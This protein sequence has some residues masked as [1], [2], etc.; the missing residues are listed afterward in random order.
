M[1]LLGWLRA[2]WQRDAIPPPAADM[3]GAATLAKEKAAN[4]SQES[5]PH[6]VIPPKPAAIEPTVAVLRALDWDK[7]DVWSAALTRACALRGIHTRLRLAAFLANVGHETNGGR[8]LVE[9]LDYAPDRL[10]AVFGLRATPEAQACCRQDG[11]PAD[12]RALANILYGG[13]WGRRNLGNTMP[14]DGWRFRG[15][16]LMQLT[17]RANY[18]RFARMIGATLD[19]AF[20][21]TLETPIGAAESAAH[22]WAAAGCND[23]ADKGDIARVRRI[24]NGGSVGLDDVQDRY[25][26]ALAQI[27]PE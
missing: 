14:D 23:A 16:G 15:R 25:R 5:L 10:R 24:V 27:V 13:E 21:R 12:Q 6:V 9:S 26:A 18:E 3:L 1:G 4:L 2:F 8:R 22:F 17:G 20:L 19:D 11:R 7:P